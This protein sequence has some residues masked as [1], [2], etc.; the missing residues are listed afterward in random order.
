MMM[1]KARAKLESY[2]GFC[3]PLLCVTI[4]TKSTQIMKPNIRVRGHYP[5]NTGKDEELGPLMDSFYLIL[6]Q[7]NISIYTTKFTSNN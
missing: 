6:R 3:K 2:K 5:V 7:G 4:L 1:A